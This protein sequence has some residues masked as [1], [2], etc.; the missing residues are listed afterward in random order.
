MIRCQTL[1]QVTVS[2]AGGPAPPEL[3]WRKHLALLVVLSR[4]PKRTRSREQLIGLLWADKAESAA[5]H[6]LNEALR[7]LRRA[8]GDDALETGGDRVSLA[9]HSVELDV[10]SLERLAES[11]DIEGACACV[12]GEFL[13]GFS[14]PGASE[15]ESWLSA[16]RRHWNALGVEVLCALAEQ[17]AA[18][19]RNAP[20]VAA[21]ERALR[22][23]PVSERAVSALLRGLVLQGSR[24]AAL[25]RYDQYAASVRERLDAEPSVAV[26]ALAERIRLDR[27]RSA[28]PASVAAASAERRRPPLVGRDTELAALLETWR[29][30]VSERKPRVALLLSEAGMGRTRLAEELAT[31]VRLEGGVVSHARAVPGDRDDPESGLLALAA[32]DLT[33]AGGVAAASPEALS[34]LAGRVPG[35]ERFGGFAA[36][37]SVPLSAALLAVLKAVAEEAPVLVWLD[38]AHLLD[39]ATFGFLERIPRDLAGLPVMILVGAAPVPTSEGIDALRVRMGR[40]LTG[41]MLAPGPLDVPAVRAL[42][43]WALDGYSPEELDRVARRLTHDTAGLPLLLVELLDAVTDGLDLAEAGQ[44]WPQAF[45]TL[46]QTMPGDLPDSI[47][48]AI[49]I[50]FRR[51]GPDAQK[52]LAVASVLAERVNP[53]DVAI[54]T[55][56]SQAAVLDALDELEWSRW[57]VAEPRGYSFMARVVRDVIARD[58]LTPGQRRRIAEGAAGP[59]R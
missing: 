54:A 26:R 53:G 43:A 52:V 8:A 15:F 9:A 59:K 37:E 18:R 51:L 32:G 2:V 38:D 44:V 40:E 47:T 11:G 21:S 19:G 20:A 12:Q 5:R 14:I 57:L 45:R 49:R 27:T 46:D 55:G 3:L 35:W 41:V 4:A 13:E 31:R 36:G 25:E 16:E 28:K 50:S 33:T 17:E 29:A 34:A 7:V 48:A 56:L 58:M 6:S 42:A 10:E 24:S 22:L 23:D 39:A 30:C 1:G